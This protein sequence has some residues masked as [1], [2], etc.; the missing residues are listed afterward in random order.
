M[1][2]LRAIR[3]FSKV[4]ETGS[5]T[6]AAVAFN[7]PPSSLSRRVADLEKSLGATL[8]KRSTRIVK[9][10]EVGQIYYNDIQQILN[11]LEKSNETVR[12]YQTTPMG[13]LRISSMVGFGDKILLPLLDEFS[14]LYPE[15]ILDVSLSDQLST[16]GRDDV[17]IA[18][19]G[20][21]APNERV[22]AI[23]LMDNSFIPVA[24]PSYLERYGKPNNALQ[25]KEHKGLYFKAPTGPT[26]WLCNVDGQ[27]HDVSGPAV[28]ISNSGPWLAK[29]ACDGEG[30]FMSTRWAL[31]SYL[32]SGAL[33]ELKFEH[34][35]A[36]TQNSDMAVY[37]LYQKQRYLVPKVKAAVDF[38]VAKI[39]EEEL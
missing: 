17:D 27:W 2:Q 31:A 20:G 37:L 24:S 12:S 36:I 15:I 6:K 39:K 22:L 33:Q 29:K 25:L 7:V 19:R 10:T 35:V 28:A 8:L 21:Y 11:Q 5:F 14:Q 4:V 18:I 23:K 38:L 9:L 26:P 3:Y 32:E 1:D 30:I 34:D 16:L 13:R